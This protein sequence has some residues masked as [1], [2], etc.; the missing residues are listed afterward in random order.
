[1]RGSSSI[2]IIII[3]WMIV[4]IMTP[5]S[6]RGI[7]FFFYHGLSDLLRPKNERLIQTLKYAAFVND[8]DSI[9][10]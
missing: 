1:M 5:S 10:Y 4:R 6:V 9:F 3:M 7:Q 8:D 2:G